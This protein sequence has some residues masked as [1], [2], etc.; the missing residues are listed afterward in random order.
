[1]KTWMKV[2][3]GI[4]AGIALIIGLVFWLTGDVAKTGDDFFA[5]VADGNN[6]QAYE[7]LSPQFKSN[8]NQA[9]F[10]AY[11]SN[12][13]LNDVKSVS[14]TSRNISGDVG[15]LSGTITTGSGDSI[16]V[17]MKVV[18]TE[19]GWKVFSLDIE[20]AG[21]A[22]GS[23][24]AVPPPEQLLQL[25]VAT[26]GAFSDSVIANDMTGFHGHISP[27]WQ[28]QITPA[29]LQ[30]TFGGFYEYAD[31]IASLKKLPPQPREKPTIGDNGVMVVKGY[32]DS[33]DTRAI[34]TYK[35]IFE[36]LKWRPIGYQLDLVK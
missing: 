5:A 9:D 23:K 21:F 13:G 31:K 3:L 24:M 16:P 19:N 17:A 4:F 33:P 1:M 35:Y 14:W 22:T 8:A 29:E 32:Y 27:T 26:T 6:E 18:K 15:D 30:E 12:I 36:G 11:L 10:D 7:L 28:E 34:F 20:M 2:V 25:I